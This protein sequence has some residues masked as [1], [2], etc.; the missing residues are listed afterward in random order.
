MD[1]ENSMKH[2]TESL[3]T[4]GMALTSDKRSMERRVR[5][6]FARRKSAKGVLALSL[7]LALTLGFAAFT[8]ACQPERGTKEQLQTQALSPIPVEQDE[9]AQEEPQQTA[10][11]QMDQQLADV[12]LTTAK[13]L[14]NSSFNA[15]SANMATQAHITQPSETLQAGIELV[16]DAD[17]FVPATEGISIQECDKSAFTVQEYKTMINTLLPNSEWSTTTAFAGISADGTIDFSKID[18]AADTELN[19]ENGSGKFITSLSNKGRNITVFRE[20][21]VIYDE[22]FLLGDAEV[23]R[24]FGEIIR[25]PITLTQ[26]AAQAKAD[27]LV[28]RF[29]AKGWAL[30]HAERACMFDMSNALL[31]R[32][33]RFQYGLSNAGLSMIADK[34]YAQSDRLSYWT[35][36][37]G[38]INV[39]VDDNG[40]GGFRWSRTYQPS[41]VSYEKPS[42][43]SAEDALKLAK[44]RIINL[45]NELDYEGARI[46][47]FDIRLANMLIG[48][49]DK[50]TGQPF[51]E[52]YEDI[53][54][55][56]PVWNISFRVLFDNG[57]S[58]FY[59]MPFSASDGGA[60]SLLDQ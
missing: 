10:P 16:V 49:N 53:A 2:S 9:G 58:E 1:K 47:V 22:V 40:V 30:E 55:L 44:S 37:A 56:I 43:I 7:V 20:D 52:V 5:G 46:E 13:E 45:Y 32:G 33:W 48:Y 8:T 3:L 15:Q 14:L 12:Q 50:L 21:T 51:P 35:I 29:N 19:A 24:E 26:D 41:D 11:V 39:Y 54:L 28:S 42:I 34:G 59:L 27:E 60:V 18:P 6:V 57:E 36:D 4:L 23:E 31:A 25:E 38:E 17:V